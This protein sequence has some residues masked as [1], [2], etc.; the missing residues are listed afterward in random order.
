MH[1]M[2]RHHASSPSTSRAAVRVTS[3]SFMLLAALTAGC[4]A[5]PEGDELDDGP[6]PTDNRSDAQSTGTVAQAAATSCSTGSVK[7]LSIQIIQEGNC[8]QE[9]AFAKVPARPNISFGPNVF[10]YLEKPARD[11]LVLALDANPGKSLTINSMLRTIAQQYLL[12]RWYQTG[13]CGIGLAAAP[14]NSNHETGL[15]L[16]TSQASSWKSALAARGFKWFGSGD[17]V[18]FDYVGTGAVSHKG[19]DVRAFQRL[20]NRNHPGDKIAV[21]GDWGPQ[22]EARMKKAPAAGFAK[23]AQ[24]GSSPNDEDVDVAMEQAPGLDGL[25]EAAPGG[26]AVETDHDDHEAIAAEAPAERTACDACVESICDLDPFCCGDWD[27]ACVA[28]T[29]EACETE[30]AISPLP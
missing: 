13:R 24:C 26:I 9:G 1:P 23:G 6:E 3:A 18:H 7:A 25:T 16:D 5:A 29:E 22:T 10:R 4:A 2:K 17:P 21:D 27:A 30:C 12:Y 14:G 19:L 20:W 8:I 15:A 28:H 11:R